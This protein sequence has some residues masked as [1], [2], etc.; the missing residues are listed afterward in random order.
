L[1]VARRLF[2]EKGI[3]WATVEDITELADYGKGT[4]Y[5]YFDSKEAMICALLKEGLDELTA[6]TEQALQK[7]P[8]GSKT[9]SAA[10]EARVDFFL[11]RPEYLL[12][13]HQVRG[14]MQLQVGAAKELRTIYD[15]HLAQ[16]TK[17]VKPA[18][19]AGQAGNARDIATAM[20]A[21]TS[22]LLTYEFLFEG[23]EA[24]RGRHQF[25]VD[26]L[27]QSLQPLLKM[28]NGPC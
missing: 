18:M 25:F 23:R 19:D 4:F 21:Y 24:G 1:E 27:D 6:K 28:G 15:A 8:T 17:L 7:V 22:G 14:M 3:Y 11:N 20:A 10:I 5:K 16:L 13:F 26:I 2:S 9:L 12:F